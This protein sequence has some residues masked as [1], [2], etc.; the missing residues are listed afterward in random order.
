MTTATA[1]AAAG[2]D[3][4]QREQLGDGSRTAA[5]RVTA[6]VLV[7]RE[8]EVGGADRAG[9]EDRTCR[10]AESDRTGES[11]AMAAGGG[12]HE[13]CGGGQWFRNAS[14]MGTRI[15]VAERVTCG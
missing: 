6:R 5:P 8:A 12:E 4:E 3:E 2:D 13:P 1:Q 11:V 10:S 15:L 14:A 7:Q 9:L